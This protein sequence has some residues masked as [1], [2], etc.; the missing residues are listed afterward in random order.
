MRRPRANRDEVEDPAEPWPTRVVTING[1]TQL[2]RYA[3]V[4]VL[5]ARY[6][7]AVRTKDGRP[8]QTQHRL[9]LHW[10]TLIT[11][12][13]GRDWAHEDDM[14]S[15]RDGNP[16]SVEPELDAVIKGYLI[17]RIH[18]LGWAS[19][20]VKPAQVDEAPDR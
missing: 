18:E 7:R 17:A 4:D 5:E 6:L 8:T 9:W 20:H 16:V 3:P 15:D 19:Q 13:T 1:V 11:E 14:H 2:R 12:L 10:E